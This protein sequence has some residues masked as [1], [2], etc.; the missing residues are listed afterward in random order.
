[1]NCLKSISNVNKTIKYLITIVVNYIFIF[2]LSSHN[3]GRCNRTSYGVV[4][5]A[6]IISSDIPRFS[7]FVDS[8]APFLIYN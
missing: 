1:M 6:N 4:S 2:T 7:V 3:K 5:A 8:L